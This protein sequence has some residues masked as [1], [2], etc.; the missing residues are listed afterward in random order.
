MRLTTEQQFQDHIGRSVTVS[1]DA[2]EPPKHHTKKHNEWRRRNFTG[3]IHSASDLGVEIIRPEST[4]YIKLVT[5][6]QWH[7]VREINVNLI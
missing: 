6:F 7:T 5:H 1:D 4:G 2:R 3:V